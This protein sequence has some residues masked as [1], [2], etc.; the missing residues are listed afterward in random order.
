M[1]SIN[2]NQKGYITMADNEQIQED[3][4]F[5]DWSDEKE[6]FEKQIEP[7]NYPV[8]VQSWEYRVSSQKQSPQVAFMFR[9]T[10]SD[11]PTDDGTP[12]FYNTT[13][14]TR[15]FRGAILYLAPAA[16]LEPARLSLAEAQAGPGADNNTTNFL[17]ALIG[18][19]VTVK[20][21]HREYQGKVSPDIQSFVSDDE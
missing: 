17:D 7:G 4:Q 10:G 1:R 13:W 3:V 9:V 18:A 21:R 2:R 5:G 16:G 15:F 8:T 12:L 20:V 6:K 11:D 14:G 19:E